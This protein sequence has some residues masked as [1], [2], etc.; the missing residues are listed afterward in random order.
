MERWLYLDAVRGLAAI[1]VAVFHYQGLFSENQFFDFGYL[2]VDV[3]FVL[4]GM[5]LQAMYGGLIEEGRIS[6]AEF[7]LARFRRLY[8]MVIIAGAAVLALNLFFVPSSNVSVGSGGALVR[9]ALLLPS[10][11]AGNAFPANGPLWSLMF[12]A[13]VNVVWFAVMRLTGKQ[14]FL[15]LAAAAVTGGGL[16]VFSHGGSLN[17]GW[18]GDASEMVQGFVRALAGFCTGALLS[19]HWPRV[20][21]GLR[22][23]PALVPALLGLALIGIRPL[24]EQALPLIADVAPVCGAI[25][26]LAA[27][28]NIKA[29]RWSAH[30]CHTLGA[31]SYPA[32]LLHAPLGRLVAA[33]L[34]VGAGGCV[35]L[36]VLLPGCYVVHRCLEI[37]IQ[38]GLK[39]LES[40]LKFRSALRALSE[41]A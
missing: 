21:A 32:Y 28:R 36:G 1:M 19:L 14:G 13:V 5:V 33:T 6:A 27:L 35:F 9:A 18:Q 37:P 22:L 3:F 17:F 38:R 29:P 7:A 30:V 2:A 25:I 20:E 15:V 8:P 16:T 10:T 12:E 24:L 23:V 31:I 40:R 4:S 41:E 39:R 34:P 26:G 11:G